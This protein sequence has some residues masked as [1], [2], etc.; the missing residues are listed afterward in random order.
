MKQDARKLDHS[1]QRSIFKA[2]QQNE[3]QVTKWIKKVFPQIKA[4]AK[5]E[6]ADF[7]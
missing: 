2:W 4:R 5:K 1:C 6:G 7:P 3:Q